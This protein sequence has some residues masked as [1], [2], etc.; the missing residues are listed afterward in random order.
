MNVVLHMT[1]KGQSLNNYKTDPLP[2][3]NLKGLYILTVTHR[4]LK[5]VTQSYAQLPLSNALRFKS[6]GVVLM[7]F[8]LI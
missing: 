7:L 4:K 5:V 3:I 2:R 8:K 1:C 6:M